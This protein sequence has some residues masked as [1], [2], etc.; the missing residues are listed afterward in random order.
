MPAVRTGILPGSP[1]VLTLAS[2]RYAPWPLVAK[3]ID[4]IHE[5]LRDTFPL[6]QPMLIQQM[7][8]AGTSDLPI[9]MLM[10]GDRSISLQIS[11][12][13]ILLATTKY[14]HFNEFSGL[15]GRILHTFIERM[16][17]MHHMNLGVRYVDHVKAGAGETLELYLDRKLFAPPFPNMATKGGVIYA[18]YQVDDIELRVRST[19]Q[20]G[21]FSIPDDLISWLAMISPTPGQ[22]KIEQLK[23]DECTIDIDAVSQFNVPVRV[24]DHFAIL[25]KLNELHKVANAFF[26]RDDVFTDHA[27]EIWKRG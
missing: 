21:L 26:R 25:S 3:H 13:Q 6:I 24:D 18:T 12:D 22:L 9:W 1:L 11:Q 5:E 17:F 2:I 16:K 23:Q 27:F 8:A 15:I 10:S 20:P 7:T 4:E 14:S 19:T